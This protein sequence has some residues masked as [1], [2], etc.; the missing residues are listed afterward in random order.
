MSRIA[1]W[2]QIRPGEG[3]LALLGAAFFASLQAAQVFSANAADALLFQRFGVEVLP[4]LFIALGAATLLTTTAYSA[5]LGRPD[6]SRISILM[7]VAAGGMGLVSWSAT[8]FAPPQIYPFLWLAVALVNAILG[9]M[10]WILA[11]EVCDPRQ[12]KR[13]FAFF[14]SAGILGSVLAGFL[15]GPAAQAFGTPTLLVGFAALLLLG[16]FVAHVWIRRFGRLRPRLAAHRSPLQDLQQAHHLVWRNATMRLT[17]I[18]GLLFSVLFFSVT[19]PFN[20]QVAAAFPSEADLA[21]FLGAFGGIATATTFAVSLLLASRVY[22]RIG[23]IN[24]IL[25]LPLVYLGGFLM[26]SIDL[27]LET[28][29][30]LR[31]A[32]LVLIGGLASTAY[33]AIFNVVP[34][35]TRARVRAYLSG[36]PAQTG[37]MLSGVLLLLGQRG[38]TQAQALAMGILVAVVC[39][40]VVWRM[41]KTYGDSLLSALREGISD[42]FAPIELQG[43]TMRKDSQAKSVAAEG[44]KDRRG[45][46]RRMAVQILVRLEA[47]E[48]AEAIGALRSDPDPDVRAAAAGALGSLPSQRSAEL[49][50][51]FLE[52]SDPAVRAAALRSLATLGKVP[53]DRLSMYLTDPDPELRAQAAIAADAVGDREASGHAISAL[54]ADDSARARLAGLKACSE[55]EGLAA[56]EQLIRVL[57]D[58]D[59][60]MR[61]AAIGAL[62]K[63]RTP[64]GMKTLAVALE[65]P[66]ARVRRAAGGALSAWEESEAALIE[67]L[68]RG[69]PPAQLEAVRAL[70]G[71][72]GRSKD[73]L[74][75]WADR[76]LQEAHDQRR[77]RLA[78]GAE[79][80]ASA[81]AYLRVLLGREEGLTQRRVLLALGS[82]ESP[83]AMR[84]VGRALQARDAD[85]RSQAMEALESIGNRRVAQGLLQLIE[86]REKDI[87]A[88]PQEA[89]EALARHPRAWYRALALRSRAESVLQEWD[90]ILRET[91]ADPDPN[92]RRAIPRPIEEGPMI[93]TS[94]TL[95]T[96]E[97][98]LFLK[99]VPIFRLLE[100]EDLEQVAGAATER[101][102]AAGEALCREGE[103][104]DELFVLIEGMVEVRKRVDGEDRL[105]RTLQAGEYVGELAILREQPRSASVIGQGE[106]RVLVLRG[107]ALRSI[108]EDRPEVGLAML[109]SMAERMSTLG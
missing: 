78:L 49:A 15:T 105:L 14:A 10:V 17:A 38:L 23:I 102:Y 88:E 81:A 67:V 66:D 20:V 7:L 34:E 11:G 33:A 99:D 86:P 27:R 51:S 5:V 39:T 79:P 61:L 48:Y 101:L 90:D 68:E 107:E 4:I 12:G 26:W 40:A 71:R 55:V 31:F 100:P 91:S 22:A 63:N 106:V 46:I 95:G 25:I 53:S 62:E 43:K 103:V 59:R 94:A 30:L 97:R 8:L 6:R 74:L 37:V 3:G 77:W 16:S 92:V 36:P 108:L 85:I 21:G 47:S 29:V 28:A 69:S 42:V 73:A 75:E 104:G 2:F 41:R 18:A 83:E 60:A 44:L 70:A 84:V 65:D 80:T 35:D 54:L 87:K 50:V 52:D 24:T 9:T 45:S 109:G 76:G 93:E 19:F 1:G 13:L 89:L 58:G 98:V 82:A 96:V 64:A 32:Q 56:T 72:G 57:E